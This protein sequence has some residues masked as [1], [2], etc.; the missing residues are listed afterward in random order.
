MQI[1][2]MKPK[3]RWL[4]ELKGLPKGV[5]VLHV[6]PRAYCVCRSAPRCATFA[7]PPIDSSS[8]IDKRSPKDYGGHTINGDQLI[9]DFYTGDWATL[10][11]AVGPTQGVW[12][13]L[14]PIIEI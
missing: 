7:A 12:F 13:A 9:G 2:N 6:A 3:K 14:P 5:E 1:N 10:V 4:R 8:E 11:Y